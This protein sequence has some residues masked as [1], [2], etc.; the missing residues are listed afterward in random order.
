MSSPVKLSSNVNS[1]K[2]SISVTSDRESARFETNTIQRLYST[3]ICTQVQMSQSSL[4]L[5]FIL[6]S[7]GP[8]CDL[9]TVVGDDYCDNTMVIFTTSDCQSLSYLRQAYLSLS[10]VRYQLHD[11]NTDRAY[12]NFLLFFC[13]KISKLYPWYRY[14]YDFVL[15][16]LISCRLVGAMGPRLRKTDWYTASNHTLSVAVSK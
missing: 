12:C 1:S 9:W 4:I 8:S 3:V 6:L 15:C 16:V 10:N 11:C 5:Q 14:T 7:I 2:Q 13:C